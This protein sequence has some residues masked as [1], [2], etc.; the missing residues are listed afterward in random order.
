MNQK[1]ARLEIA[2]LLDSNCQ[3]CEHKYSHSPS[4]C[5]KK[6]GIGKR[7]HTLGVVLSGKN[8]GTHHK[9]KE[10]EQWDEICKKTVQLRVKKMK[11]IDI[12]KKF[13][14]SVG[15]LRKQL[16]QRNMHEDHGL[17]QK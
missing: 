13:N 5:W 11:Y 16:K 4:Y 9:P 3:E 7:L 1:E 14:V 17:L 12:A 2:N 10:R 15:Y 8:V 6:C